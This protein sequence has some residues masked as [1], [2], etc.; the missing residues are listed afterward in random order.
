MTTKG[1]TDNNYVPFHWTTEGLGFVK[2]EECL[3]HWFGGDKTMTEL[4]ESQ[5]VF[6]INEDTF[7]SVKRFI[8]DKANPDKHWSN[9]L[10]EAFRS[11]LMQRE[12]EDEFWCSGMCEAGLFYINK[13]I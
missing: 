9:S 6:Q 1:W 4:R 5:Q 2:F 13:P 3:I 12:L 8:N 10:Q 11:M 7:K